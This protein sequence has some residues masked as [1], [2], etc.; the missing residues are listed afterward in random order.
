M[1]PIEESSH[2]LIKRSAKPDPESNPSAVA[3]SAANAISEPSAGFLPH[4]GHGIG[5]PGSQIGLA[6]NPHFGLHGVHAHQ[7][8][9]SHVATHGQAG[10]RHHPHSS[11]AI[12][13]QVHP[14]HHGAHHGGHPGQH[15]GHPGHHLAHPALHGGHPHSR[16]IVHVSSRGL[17]YEYNYDIGGA[18]P[19]HH[20]TH[21]IH[22]HRQQLHGFPIAHAHGKHR[23]H[24]HDD[25]EY[26]EEYYEEEDDDK[27]ND[28][29]YL[30]TGYGFHHIDS[31]SHGD[32]RFRGRGLHN[33]LYNSVVTSHPSLG[34]HRLGGPVGHP[35]LGHHG[36]HPPIHAGQAHGL[37][38]GH[39]VGSRG[40]GLL[41]HGFAGA[42]P[43]SGSHHLFGRGGPG[44]FQGGHG[45]HGSSPLA[46]HG[47]IH[48]GNHAGH[49]PV[50]HG[51]GTF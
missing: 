32:G 44:V 30:T 17:G 6:N 19:R 33:G 46:H 4:S 21:L 8:L 23:D 45:G 9:P 24:Y 5:H 26:E 47:L 15:G 34:G 41:G 7:S 37:G 16:G 18:N 11:A 40:P 13:P 20:G 10:V 49:H 48:H 43:H 29:N 42:G 36:H 51:I 35:G 28:N 50:H 31:H 27:Y 38:V 22:K 1:V 2:F 14:G 12:V 25:D 39:G 3:D